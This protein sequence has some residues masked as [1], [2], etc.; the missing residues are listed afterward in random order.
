MSNTAAIHE[1]FMNGS[2]TI[3]PRVG[4]G[5]GG[6]GEVLAKAAY[7]LTTRGLWITHRPA[8]RAPMQQSF[9]GGVW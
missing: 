4:G 8:T 3:P 2:R 6:G 7:N 9:D 1:G 5:V